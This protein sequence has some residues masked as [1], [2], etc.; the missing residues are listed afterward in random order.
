MFETFQVSGLYVISAAVLSLYASGRITGCVLD[1]G[2]GASHT[3]PVY[4][5]YA[6]PHAIV[7]LQDG[8]AGRDLTDYM[9]RILAERGYRFNASSYADRE[10]V[11][12]VKEKLAYVAED[13]D[14]EMKT[15]AESSSLEQSY[16]LP[17]GN[18]IVI[19][20][21]RFRCPELLFGK[22]VGVHHSTFQTIM[23]CAV[24]VRKVRGRG[25]VPIARRLVVYVYTGYA[26]L[27]LREGTSSTGAQWGT[28]LSTLVNPAEPFFKVYSPTSIP[29]NS[30]PISSSRVATRCSSASPL[31]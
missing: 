21:E 31:A 22:D 14:Q 3:V 10:V 29:R 16:E 24:D 20:N 1:S 25:V 9:A 19:G 8:L 4:E 13:F 30:T 2:D 7:R 6:I 26:P 11:R 28:R 12:A 15:A 23:K 5:G 18:V 27:L 17:D